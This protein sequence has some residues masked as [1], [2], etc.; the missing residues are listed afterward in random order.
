MF[1]NFKL[2]GE[3]PSSNC[4]VWLPL[5]LPL[6]LPIFEAHRGLPKLTGLS[7]APAFAG[8]AYHG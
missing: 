6:P 4:F 5:A 7:A 2:V 1:P 8:D 3:K